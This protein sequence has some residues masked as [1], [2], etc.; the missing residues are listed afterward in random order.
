LIE[1]RVIMKR[2]E[3]TLAGWKIIWWL[4]KLFGFP[5]TIPWL[6]YH[7]YDI[8]QQK[9]KKAAFSNKVTA[10]EI[11]LLQVKKYEQSISLN[12]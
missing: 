2:E 8:M 9:R 12:I 4:F 3:E 11:F 6:V 7:F 1:I 5:I 10:C